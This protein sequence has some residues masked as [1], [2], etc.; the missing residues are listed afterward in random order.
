QNRVILSHRAVLEEE[1]ATKKEEILNTLQSG[2]VIDGVVQ[3]LTNFGAFVDV[4]GVDGL[5]HIS[6]LAHKHVEHASDVVQEGDTISVEILSVD[7]ETERIS[8]S[9]KNTIPG[10]W[11]NIEAS[12]AQGDVVE[13]TVQRLVDFGAFVE[14][15]EGV[16]GLVHISQIANRHVETPH[17][18]LEVGQTV[19]VKVLDV[20]EENERI[21]LSIKALEQEEEAKEFQKYERSDDQSGF[22]LSDVIGDKLDKYKK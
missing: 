18:V 7:P 2:Q 15:K 9:H 19:S 11:T 10:P 22:S 5:V 12:I 8:L 4:G 17:E 6:E 3:R 14:V 1:Q 20:D 16:E 21:S 13:G